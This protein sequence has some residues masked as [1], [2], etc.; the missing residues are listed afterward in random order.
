MFGFGNIDRFLMDDEEVVKEWT[1]KDW[2]AIYASQYRLFFLKKGVLNKKFI[3]V[4]YNHISSLEFSKIR[5]RERLIASIICLSLSFITYYL[6]SA[7]FFFRV[8][9]DFFYASLFLLIIALGLFIW[10]I[11]GVDKFL[12]HINGRKSITVSRELNELFK[13]IREIVDKPIYNDDN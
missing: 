6:T 5:P 11:I 12:L 1:S 2:D 9:N 7:R 4:S 8:M 3:E 13:F 10:F